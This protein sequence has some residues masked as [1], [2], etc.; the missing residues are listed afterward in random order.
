[1]GQLVSI[2]E[3]ANAG[4]PKILETIVIKSTKERVWQILAD[5]DNEPEY[6]WGTKEIHN[7]SEEGNVVKRE[8]T[9]NFRNHKILQKVILKPM[10]EIEFQYLSGLTQ[11]VKLLKLEPIS[12]NEQKLTAYWEVHF[13]GIYRLASRFIGGHIRKGTTD[14]LQRIKDACEVREIS[15]FMRSKETQQAS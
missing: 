2:G 6:W 4:L 15:E 7:T 10:D 13:P 1:M 5:L 8:I 9:Q 12:N 3:R 14:A 11:G